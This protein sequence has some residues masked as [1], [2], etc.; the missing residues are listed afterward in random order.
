MR[1]NFRSIKTKVT[2][3]ATGTFVV[4]LVL[5]GVL[6]AL[7][8]KQDM[9]QVLGNA[10]F[11]FVSSV[12]DEIDG[13]LRTFQRALIVAAKALP[14]G[15]AADRGKLGT[16]LENQ[17]ALRTLFDGLTVLNRDGRVLVDLPENGIRGLSGA[18]REYLQ[19]TVNERIP[20]ISEPFVGAVGR[21]PVVVLTAPILDARGEVVAVLAGTLNLFGPNFLGEIATR[22][23]GKTGSFALFGRNRTIIL[24]RDS[25]RILTQGPP[26]GASP[27]FDHA[28]S[29]R[30]GWEEGSN[31]RG[32]RAMFSYAQLNMVPWVL[33]SALPIEEAYAPIAAA[34]RRIVGI[35]ALLAVVL[36][37]IVWLAIG[38]MTRPLLNLRDAIRRIRDDPAAVPEVRVRGKDEIGELAGDFNALVKERAEAARAAREGARRLRMITDHI[39]ALIS[40]VDSAERYVYAN[41][42]YREWFGVTPKDIEGRALEEVL[43]E[44]GYALR[45]ARIRE[46]LAGKEVSFELSMPHAGKKR[47][48]QVRYVP[49]MRD[50]GSVAGFYVLASDV[51]G[52]KRTERRLRESEQQLS[53]ALESSRLALFDWN[54]S[55]GEVFLSDQWAVML[56]GKPAP[57][58]TSFAALEGLVHPEDRAG[59]G[60]LVHDALTGA[61][62]HYR[63]EHRVRTTKGKWVWIQSEGRVTTRDAGGRALRFVGINADITERKR[64]EEELI[65]SRA[66]LE[67]AARHDSLTGLPNRRLLTDRL[68]QALARARRTKQLMALLCLD[69][70]RFKAINDTMGHVAGDA[71]LVAF[72]ERLNGCVR[73]S[74]T[75]ARLGGDEFVILLE[76]VQHPEDV[77]AIAVKIIEAMRRA[78]Q[79]ESR[80]FQATTSIGIACTRGATTAQDLLKQ[81]DSALYDAKG[82]GR[83]RYSVFSAAGGEKVSILPKRAG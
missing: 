76:D 10:Q 79:V 39:P 83:N 22:N 53:L 43:G 38:R 50:D 57:T 63:A 20:V 32:L 62:L 9:S 70:D 12:A 56:G 3:V 47:H 73:E 48:T 1:V 6:Q 75:V 60:R 15:V 55:T 72:A 42:T 68:D 45:V 34:Q 64:A 4:L 59:L 51:T 17:P 16:L 74:D 30:E 33:N 54:V 24:S 81:A 49:E 77:E 11:A 52:L 71:L 46:A 18:E 37:P 27:N 29:G 19:R 14:P 5:V 36:A 80:R 35:S 25:S 65:Q 82:A 66:E 78:F 40:Y 58:R 21:Q 31:S 2:L 7:Q 23:V 13:K 69:L 41:A 8:V 67:R 44:E 28:V 61:R 26:P